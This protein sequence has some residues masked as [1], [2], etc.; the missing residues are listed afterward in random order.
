MKISNPQGIFPGGAFLGV[1]SLGDVSGPWK[2]NHPWTDL[3]R[4]LSSTEPCPC[5]H[6]GNCVCGRHSDVINAG[7]SGC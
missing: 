6:A 4:L 7:R 1:I 2:R 5:V 3:N